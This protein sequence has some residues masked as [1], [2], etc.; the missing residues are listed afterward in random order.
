MRLAMEPLPDVDE[1]DDDGEPHRE[2]RPTLERD[3]TV[4]AT[5]QLAAKDALIAAKEAEIATLR[6]HTRTRAH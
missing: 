5:E 6:A 4:S 2:P 3:A 1:F